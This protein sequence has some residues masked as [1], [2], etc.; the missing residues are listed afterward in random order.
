M[1]TVRGEHDT[2]GCRKGHTYMSDRLYRRTVF[3][4]R[5]GRIYYWVLCH[6]GVANG[7]R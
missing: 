6:E 1:S 3:K 5:C 4:T 2:S 7:M